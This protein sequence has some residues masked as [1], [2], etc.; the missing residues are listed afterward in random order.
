MTFWA[1]IRDT[2]MDVVH[3]V[4][5]DIVTIV[6]ADTGASQNVT[7]IYTAPYAAVTG[8]VE[9]SVS[10]VAPAFTLRVKDCE[11]GPSQGD[12][13]IDASAKSWIISDVQMNGDGAIV[14]Y[15]YEVES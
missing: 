7:A 1:S 2:A 11:F 10:T 6:S 14:C 4:F 8:G 13:I 12:T 9:R 5:G 15:V 3:G